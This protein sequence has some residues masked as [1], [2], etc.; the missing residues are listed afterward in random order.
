MCQVLALMF[1]VS[2]SSVMFMRHVSCTV[3][4]GS[5]VMKWQCC[6]MCHVSWNANAVSCVMCQA[7]RSKSKLCKLLGISLPLADA[8]ASE[9]SLV[10]HPVIYITL[11]IVPLGPVILSHK[12]DVFMWISGNI[13]GFHEWCSGPAQQD[14]PAPTHKPAPETHQNRGRAIQVNFI[15]I[16]VKSIQ[17]YS[18]QYLLLHYKEHIY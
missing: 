18:V 1:H 16:F 10:H 6:V 9:V 3:Y 8:A 7:G 2:C 14:Q 17:Y 5:C 4:T 15:S 12:L 11:K 13:G